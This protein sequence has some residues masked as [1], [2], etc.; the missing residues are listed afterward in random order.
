MGKW[1][2]Q[3]TH[4]VRANRVGEGQKFLLCV[5]AF[6]WASAPQRVSISLCVPHRTQLFWITACQESPRTDSCSCQPLSVSTSGFSSYP[7]LKKSHAWFPSKPNS[8]TSAFTPIPSY[9]HRALAFPRPPFLAP[10]PRPQ[11]QGSSSNINSVC[12][13][14]LKAISF[15]NPVPTASVHVAL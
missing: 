14:P 8:S 15:T 4:S 1:R 3:R 11:R 2:H 6:S 12:S 10:S 5:T 7:W 9:P 13:L